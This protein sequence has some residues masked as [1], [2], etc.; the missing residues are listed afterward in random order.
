M[1]DPNLKHYRENKTANV[2]S[3]KYSLILRRKVPKQEIP[4]IDMTEMPGFR[5]IWNYDRSVEAEAKYSS[6]S[7]TKL[8][9][10]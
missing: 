1:L 2:M 4:Y 3:D 5:L 9:V 8:F 7:T 10:R 6:F